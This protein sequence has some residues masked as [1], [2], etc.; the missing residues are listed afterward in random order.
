MN[1]ERRNQGWTIRDGKEVN[2]QSDAARILGWVYNAS[3]Y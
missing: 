2:L 1:G 3:P